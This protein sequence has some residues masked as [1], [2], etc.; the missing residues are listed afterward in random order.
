MIF[1]YRAAIHAA[2][3]RADQAL[4]QLEGA[5]ERGFRDFAVLEASPYFG[6][7]RDDPRFGQ[8]LAEYRG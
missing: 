6:Q 3:G 7:L 1:Y 5:F 8:L 4:E 2:A